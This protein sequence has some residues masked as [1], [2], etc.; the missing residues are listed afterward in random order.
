MGESRATLACR[1]Y[2]VWAGEV[3]RL[4]KAIAAA[5]CP[6]EIE[7]AVS[8]FSEAKSREIWKGPDYDPRRPTLDEIA[9]EVA[10]CPTCT[11][12]VDLI[13]KRRHARM[14]WGVAKQAVRRVART[15]TP[16]PTEDASDG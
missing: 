12:L 14:R 5:W 8:C 7:Q 4:N 16:T 1:E 15:A 10:A 9:K 13:R 3:A 6:R 2:N 11:E